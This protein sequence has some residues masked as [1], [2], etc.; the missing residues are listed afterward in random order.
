MGLLDKLT[1]NRSELN[2]EAGDPDLRP[3]VISLAPVHAVDWLRDVIAAM[4]RWNVAEAYHERGMIHATHKTR[5]FGF[6]DDI[7]IGFE[8]DTRGSRIEARSQSR[9]G[10]GDFGQND[11]NLRELTKAI[12]QAEA[13]RVA[14]LPGQAVAH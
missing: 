11:R 4:P 9:L 2:H 5:V 10:K 1:R 6:V 8:P 14:R 7:H 12:R 13:D 3:V